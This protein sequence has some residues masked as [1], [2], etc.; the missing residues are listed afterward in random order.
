MI[1]RD[2]RDYIKDIVDAIRDR[3]YFVKDM[4]YHEFLKDKKTIYAVVRG[5]EI[6]GEATKSIPRDL[7]EKYPDI[8]WKKMAG[9]RDKLVHEYFGIDKEIL[10]EVAKNDIPALKPDIQKVWDNIKK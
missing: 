7:K 4:N 3:E 10:W 9:M 5:V 8:S 1:K 2:Y 6:I